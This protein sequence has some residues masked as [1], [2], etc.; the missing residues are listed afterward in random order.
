MTVLAAACAVLLVALGRRG[1]GARRRTAN[2]GGRPR[3]RTVGA[4]VVCLSALA[5]F[6]VVVTTVGMRAALVLGAAVGALLVLRARRDARP[7]P[8]AA[9][10]L[11]LEVI[12]ACLDAG[13]MTP[14]AVSA[15]APTAAPPAD[16]AL[17]RVAAS[18][19]AGAPAQAVWSSFAAECRDWEPVARACARTDTSGAAVA[20]E[21]RRIAAR[22]RSRETSDRKRAVGRTSVWLVLP[23]GVCFLPAFVLVGV[24][25]LLLAA[26]PQLLR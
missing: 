11:V 26:A 10:S 17:R 1:R 16:A 22:R 9:G 19:R 13:A 14:A 21:L 5:A 3:T 7:P 6:V 2:H 12:A 24:A 4:N 23:L 25:P 15:A 18:L 8:A 20:D